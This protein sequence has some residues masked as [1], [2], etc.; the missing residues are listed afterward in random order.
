VLVVSLL[1]MFYYVRSVSAADRV[2]T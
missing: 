1:P 2:A